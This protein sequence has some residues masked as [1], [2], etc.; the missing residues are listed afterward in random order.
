MKQTVCYSTSQTHQLEL[1]IYF[2]LICYCTYCTTVLNKVTHFLSDQQ[3]STLDIDV[4]I[5]YFSHV[6]HE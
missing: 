1:Q 4:F 3:L 2:Y 5:H 6:P